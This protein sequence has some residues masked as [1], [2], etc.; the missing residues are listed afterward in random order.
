MYRERVDGGARQQEKRTAKNNTFM[1]MVMACG[2]LEMQRER[3]CLEPG[4][5]TGW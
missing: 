4:S 2:W 1:D 3:N 5:L